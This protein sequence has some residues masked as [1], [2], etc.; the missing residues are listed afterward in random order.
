MA[1]GSE[2]WRVA[3]VAGLAVLFVA[4]CSHETGREHTRGRLHCAQIETSNFP[5]PLSHIGWHVTFDGETVEMR[6]STAYCG[7]SP[8]P[9]VEVLVLFRDAVRV[10]SGRPVFSE[11]HGNPEYA[12]WACNGRCLVYRGGIDHVDTGTYEPFPALP[13]QP[14][15][16]SPDLHTV[17]ASLPTREATYDF[18]VLDLEAGTAVRWSVPRAAA[19]WLKQCDDTI[20]LDEFTGCLGRRG[21]R[22]RWERG[23]GGRDG[24][25]PPRGAVSEPATW[26][27]CESSATEPPTEAG[28]VEE[29][30]VEESTAE[31]AGE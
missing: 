10:E 30:D 25:V 2:R 3:G 22:F 7:V 28:D 24:L 21:E 12:L 8:D 1:L 31:G 5:Y 14:L 29:S 26:Q 18:C 6:R 27:R 15:S 13:G 4:A 11:L 16:L 20:G 17:V 9:S 19:P 23:A